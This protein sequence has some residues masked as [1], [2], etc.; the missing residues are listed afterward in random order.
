MYAQQFGALI[1]K[2]YIYRKEKKQIWKELIFKHKLRV[3]YPAHLVN[4]H[5]F[6][7]VILWTLS[8]LWQ[9]FFKFQNVHTRP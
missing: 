5:V 2:K 1:L 3:F 4:I 7:S 6:R 8:F 9:P